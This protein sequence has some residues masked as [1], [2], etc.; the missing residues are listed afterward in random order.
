MTK[1]WDWG[2][3]FSHKKYKMVTFLRPQFHQ[4]SSV[5]DHQG[6]Y[7]YLLKM[8]FLDVYYAWKSNERVKIYGDLKF[9]ILKNVGND[10]K[11]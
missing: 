5:L 7:R 10:R 4:Y 1:N 2:P 11:I 3:P 6:L 9:Q 8:I